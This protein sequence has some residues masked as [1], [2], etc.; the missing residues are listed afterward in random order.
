MDG[1]VVWQKWETRWYCWYLVLWYTEYIEVGTYRGVKTGQGRRVWVNCTYY[2]QHITETL[3]A[4]AV[5]VTILSVPRHTGVHV[6]WDP[7]ML[8]VNNLLNKL[9]SSKPTHASFPPV[10]SAQAPL[11]FARLWSSTYQHQSNARSGERTSVKYSLDVQAIL[12]RHLYDMSIY[13]RMLV[14]KLLIIYSM[15]KLSH[16]WWIIYLMYNNQYRK[17]GWKLK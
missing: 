8:P 10:A 3:A 9:S 1:G 17:A 2:I 4:L 12:C 13:I 14:T 7:Y 15:P 6:E 5:A 11:R 16:F